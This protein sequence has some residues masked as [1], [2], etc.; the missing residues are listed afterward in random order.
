MRVSTDGQTLAGQ[1]AIRRC[2][3]WSGLR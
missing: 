3:G 2:I 1:E